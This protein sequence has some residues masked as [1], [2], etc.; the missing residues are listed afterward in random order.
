M[1]KPQSVKYTRMQM[2]ALMAGWGA[3]EPLPQG[4][5]RIVV[6]LH[7]KTGFDVGRIV[8][9]K[10]RLLYEATRSSPEGRRLYEEDRIRGD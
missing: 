2:E 10:K 3:T 6:T 4:N 5:K 8:I 9:R 1:C 7:G